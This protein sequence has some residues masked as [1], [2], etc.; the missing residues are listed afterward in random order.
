MSPIYGQLLD[1]LTACLCAHCRVPDVKH[2][3]DREIKCHL[4]SSGTKGF[5]TQGNSASG[6]RS[7][8]RLC[9]FTNLDTLWLPRD[10]GFFRRG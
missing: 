7:K 3:R 8:S 10:A 9:A 4:L 1:K 5:L 2:N 6:T